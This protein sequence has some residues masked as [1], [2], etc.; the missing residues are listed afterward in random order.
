MNT[1]TTPS[2]ASQAPAVNAREEARKHVH[3]LTAR[4]TELV[5]QVIAKGMLGVLEECI[6]MQLRMN[7]LEARATAA[8]ARAILAAAAPHAQAPAA[9][10]AE[11]SFNQAEFD[12]MVEKGTK[13]WA[14]VPAPRQEPQPVAEQGELPSALIGMEVSMDVSTGD[15]DFDHRIFGRIEGLMAKGDGTDIIL[16]VEESRNFAAS[17]PSKLPPPE[18]TW[19]Y[20]HCRA[21]GM[22]CKSASGKWEEDIGLWTVNLTNEIKA[23]RASQQAAEP[24]ARKVVAWTAKDGDEWIVYDA[25]SS[26]GQHIAKY[27]TESHGVDVFPIYEDCKP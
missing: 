5:G 26:T 20:T 22:D 8:E 13:A 12:A 17:Q 25:E 27:Q 21:I 1:N 9:P 18:L 4:T 24:V 14:G 11:P 16:A 2:T 19:L 7:A 15:E 3:S 6:E 10:V 23:L